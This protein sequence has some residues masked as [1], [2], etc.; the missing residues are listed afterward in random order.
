M[1]KIL[2]MLFA[3]SL[4][5]ATQVVAAANNETA[6]VSNTRIVKADKDT[7]LTY[8]KVKFFVPAGQALVLG[9]VDNGSVLVRAARLEGV[10]IG[11]ATIDSKLPVALYVDPAT[12]AVIVDQGKDVQ[13]VDK[14]GRTAVMSQGAAVSGEDIRVSVPRS[15][16]VT[17]PL[18]WQTK[19]QLV[20]PNPTDNNNTNQ[21]VVTYEAEAETYPNFLSDDEVLSSTAYEQAV[22]D[23]ENSL[24]PSAPRN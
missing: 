20:T 8:G 4:L 22:Q 11:K 14:D 6:K 13:L 18:S 1:K 21:P 23:V 5:G 12:N 17:L 3:L 19:V 9:Q 7:N 15:F 2:V 24:S 10:K 16:L